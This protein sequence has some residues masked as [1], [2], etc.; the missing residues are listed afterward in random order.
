MG[1]IRLALTERQEN[2]FNRC[3]AN[4]EFAA[5]RT[6]VFRLRKVHA[7]EIEAL[8][9]VP[10]QD[11]LVFHLLRILG[12][13]RLLRRGLLDLFVP[14]DNRSEAATLDCKAT[15]SLS[16][17]MNVSRPSFSLNELS[18]STTFSSVFLARKSVINMVAACAQSADFDHLTRLCWDIFHAEQ[19]HFSVVRGWY[20]KVHENRQMNQS[21]CEHIIAPCSMPPACPGDSYALSYKRWPRYS[22]PRSRQRL[23]RC[24][25]RG[26]ERF[27]CDRLC[28]LEREAPPG[29]PAA[30]KSRVSMLRP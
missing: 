30:S 8:F 9:S 13:G 7:A 15:I 26:E 2:T 29:K 16:G 14:A 12:E 20:Q 6:V 24:R 18:R 1:I 3:R 19:V 27:S 21:L 10:D 23:R 5:A 28:S 11:K 22:S 4:E 25:E 17:R